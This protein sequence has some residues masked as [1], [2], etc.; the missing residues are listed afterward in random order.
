MAATNSHPFVS[1]IVD[2]LL[3]AVTTISVLWGSDNRCFRH[4]GV[5]DGMHD[6]ALCYGIFVA[7]AVLLFFMRYYCCFHTVVT[8]MAICTSKMY[9]KRRSTNRSDLY[10]KMAKYI[11]V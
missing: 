1:F 11:L 3:R 5:G 6:I 7:V 10:L 4:G 9:L 8:W 2:C